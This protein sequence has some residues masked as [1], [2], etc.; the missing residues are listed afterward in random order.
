[1][2]EEILIR[3]EGMTG[4]ITLNRPDALNALTA[5][6]VNEIADILPRWR[7][8]PSVQ[9]VIID[10]TGDRAFA[11]A[12]TFVRFMMP[13]LKIRRLERAFGGGNMRSM[14]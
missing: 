7:D 4:R 8:D 13:G 9:S 10:G 14:R 3:K 12:A 2:S 5:T 1:M 11:R 6:M